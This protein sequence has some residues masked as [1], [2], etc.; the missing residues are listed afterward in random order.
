[1]KFKSTRNSTV[2]IDPKEALLNGISKEGGLYV[3]DTFPKLGNI[4]HMTEMHYRDLAYY[5]L[6][7]FFTDFTADELMEC[8][9]GAYNDINFSD[10]HIAPIRKANGRYFLELYHGR[11]SAFKDMALS[12][13]PYLIQTA[14][15]SSDE[16]DDIV[17]LVATSGDT[18]KAALEGF[19]DIDNIKIA[20]LFPE[21]G[22]SSIQKLQMQTQEGNN[23]YVLGVIGNFDDCQT[24]VKNIFSNKELN[25][26]LNKNKIQL[27]SANSINVGRLL[28]QIVYYFSSYVNMLKYGEIEKDEKVNIVV[29]TGN[30]G[31]ILAAYYAMKMGLPINKLICASNDNNVLTEFINEGVYDKNRDLKLTTSP[32]M[33]VLVSSN[34]E[35]FIY[36]MSNNNTELVTT[37]MEELDT[38]GSYKVGR[39]ISENMSFMK[40]YYANEEEVKENILSTFIDGKYL[41]DTHTAVANVAYNKYL[42]ETRDNTKTIIDSTASPYK[43][44]KDILKALELD[45]DK[46]DD[47]E[48]MEKLSKI[49]ET[50]IPVNLSS[51]KDKEVR[52][53][54]FSEKSEILN[55][56]K[57]FIGEENA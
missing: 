40:A 16:F 14:L 35:R 22:V 39:T 2:Y 27:S 28:P 43:F 26:E 52:F 55:K 48:I 6:G 7:K 10:P 45:T 13:F 21:D 51:L 47:F 8:V 30:F 19:K 1:M 31:N 25:E 44:A 56:I 53:K 9:H 11:T 15:N 18:G 46:L 38:N 23:T 37:L 17:I 3:P 36:H 20:V 41:I 12:I 50:T 5:I 57:S 54:D 24:T 49:T 33:D 34:V 32:S 29:P 42:K 4:E